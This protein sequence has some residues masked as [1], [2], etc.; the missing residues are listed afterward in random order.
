MRGIN[1]NIATML[2]AVGLAI[3]TGSGFAFE[4]EGNRRVHLAQLSASE[5]AAE[6]ERLHQEL[7]SDNMFLRRAAFEAASQS[8]DPLIVKFAID[9]ALDSEDLDLQ[10]DGLR[11]WL[12]LRERIAVDLELPTK[13]TGEQTKLYDEA[14]PLWFRVQDVSPRELTLFW[15][16][17]RNLNYRWHGNFAAGGFRVDNRKCRLE[18]RVIDRRELAGAYSCGATA[19]LLARVQVE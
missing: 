1:M 7:N 16:D 8:E 19:S 10:S 17:G 3:G 12:S 6:L 13:P 2:V 4:N 9:A 15:K 18:M 14:Q 5:R 11:L